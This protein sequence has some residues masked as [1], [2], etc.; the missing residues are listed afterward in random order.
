MKIFD[1]SHPSLK[2]RCVRGQ[3]DSEERFPIE[4]RAIAAQSGIHRSERWTATLAVVNTTY[5]PVSRK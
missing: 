1:R 5:M 4:T 2:S 3:A